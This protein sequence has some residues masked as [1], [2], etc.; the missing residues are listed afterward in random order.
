MKPLKRL[1]RILTL[2]L[3]LMGFAESPSPLSALCAQTWSYTFQKGDTLGRVSQKLYGTSKKWKAIAKWNQLKPPYSIQVGQVLTLLEKPAPK[4]QKSNQLKTW[5]YETQ[6]NEILG[7]ISEKLYGDSSLWI[8]IAH[9]NHIQEPYLVP[10]HT[11]LVLYK[12]PKTPP[13]EVEKQGQAQAAKKHRSPHISYHPKTDTYSYKDKNPERFED[14]NAEDFLEYS[15]ETKEAHE[16]FEEGR[17]LFED[18][19]F[20]E[21][22][23]AF[24]KSKAKDD[25]PIAVW[26]YEMR[27]L[28]GLNRRKE[29]KK[30]AQALLSKQP[31]LKHVSYIQAVLE[32]KKPKKDEF[33]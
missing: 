28:R 23:L 26:I 21:A 6:D 5:S 17:D 27:C 16:V 22:L 3:L 12:E 19:N 11:P 20:Q 14:S 24:R 9:W 4:K 15:G 1:V 25:T 10:A 13:E 29:A 32:Q 30:V 2:S 8:D 31:R 18:R 7:E 33:P